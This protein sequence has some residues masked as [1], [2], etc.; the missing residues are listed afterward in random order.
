VTRLGGGRANRRE[1]S[2]SNFGTAD[3]ESAA[4]DGRMS[5]DA[6]IN[7]ILKSWKLRQGEF[8]NTPVTPRAGN[9]G[10]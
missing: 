3:I 4:Q 7:T 10:R 5:L 2:R 8:A 1:F 9:A 6:D